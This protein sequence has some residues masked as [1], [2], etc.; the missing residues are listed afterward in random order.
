VFGRKEKKVDSVA[1]FTA[2]LDAAIAAASQAGVK[3]RT[4]ADITE[5]RLSGLQTRAALAWHP[6]IVPRVYDGATG[7]LIQ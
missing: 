7:K 1:Q 6:N 3:P 4:L 5:S 2:S